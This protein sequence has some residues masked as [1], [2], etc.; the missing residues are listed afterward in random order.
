LKNNWLTVKEVASIVNDNS[1]KLNC[2]E[3]TLIDINVYDDKKATVLEILRKQAETEEYTGIRA[4]QLAHLIAIEQSKLSIHEKLEEID[5][6]WS[7][8][9]RPE[10]WMDFIYYMPNGKANTEEGVY[11]N[12]LTFL[13]DEKKKL[14]ERNN[15]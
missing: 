12:F 9:D 4:W 5:I 6:Q 3:K 2:D 1:E 7:R 14:T 8:F 11:Q 10:S 13:N 15:E